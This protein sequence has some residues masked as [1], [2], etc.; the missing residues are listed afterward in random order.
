[1]LSG[2]THSKC[3]EHLASSVHL[4]DCEGWWLSGCCCSVA[5]QILVVQARSVLGS[6]PCLFIFLYFHFITSKFLYFQC[7][8]KCSEHLAFRVSKPLSMGSLLMKRNFW[9]T[10]NGV[11]MTN[12]EWLPGVQLRHSVPPVQY[13][14]RIVQVARL[15]WLSGRA[16]AAQARGVLSLTPSNC[17]AGLFT[18]LFSSDNIQTPDSFISSVRQ[19]ALSCH[20]WLERYS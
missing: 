20:G 3:P 15:S 2:I 1:M 7:E 17:C 11:L 6:T 13:I 4:E 5:D 12:T 19:D 10:L 9:S 8:A 16:L 18:C 14:Q